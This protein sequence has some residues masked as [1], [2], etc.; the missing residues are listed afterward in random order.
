MCEITNIAMTAL[1]S[2]ATV[3]DMKKKA[4]SVRILVVLTFLSVIAAVVQKL[5]PW[6]LAGGVGTGILFFLI[7]QCTGEEIGY[8]DS[9]LILILGIYAGVSKLI[10]I[11]FAASFGAGIFSLIFCVV[12]KWNRRYSIPFIPFLTAAFIGVMYL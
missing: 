1:L 9:W 7:S 11:L 6:E 12:Y 2:A 10:L 8:G 4:I 5:N 3:S